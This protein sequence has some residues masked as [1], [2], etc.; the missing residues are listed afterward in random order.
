MTIKMIPKSSFCDVSFK[1]YVVSHI[2]ESSTED[3]LCKQRNFR[4]EHDGN[5]NL[6]VW[7]PPF[8]SAKVLTPDV[9]LFRN[10]FCVLSLLF[11]AS[12]ECSSRRLSKCKNSAQNVSQG[13]NL[14]H[15]NPNFVLWFRL[16]RS[17]RAIGSQVWIIPHLRLSMRSHQDSKRELSEK[18]FNQLT[19]FHTSVVVWI[20]IL[21]LLFILWNVSEVLLFIFKQRWQELYWAN[22][23]MEL[24]IFN[25]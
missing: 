15:Q 21:C 25:C 13:T 6:H 12:P 18:K 5:A 17:E 22:L 8:Y 23:Y 1:S 11:Q 4:T 2:L 19:T 20:R 9:W 14:A 10:R 16:K 7:A 24:K 3:A